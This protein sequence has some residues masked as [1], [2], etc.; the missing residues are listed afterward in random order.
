VHPPICCSKSADDIY[1]I[2]KQNFDAAYGGNRA[3]IP[4]F[5]HTPW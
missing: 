5:I 3:P 1:N 4:I 2:M